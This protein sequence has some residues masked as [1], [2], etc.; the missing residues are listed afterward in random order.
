MF[1]AK[2]FLCDHFGTV[3]SVM[4]FASAYG[5]SLSQAAVQKWFQR[6]SMPGQ[7]LA[8]LLG[9]LELEGGR[10]ISIASYITAARIP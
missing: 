1:D 7:E 4:A 5:V 10:P 8:L 2:K 3:G 9:F 6:S